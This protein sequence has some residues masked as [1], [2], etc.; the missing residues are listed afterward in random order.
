MIILDENVHQHSIQA[1]IASW[2]SGQV[3]TLNH[4]ITS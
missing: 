2:Y 4:D 1:S 3:G